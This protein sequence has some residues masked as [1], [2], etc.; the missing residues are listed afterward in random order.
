MKLFLKHLKDRVIFFRSLKVAL[1]VG[2]ILALINHY[3][4]I[5]NG[6]FNRTNTIQIILTYLVPYCV[7]TY[8]SVSHACHIEFEKLKDS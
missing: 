5:L 7:A 2:T 8:A 6:T 4:A 1:F 3:D